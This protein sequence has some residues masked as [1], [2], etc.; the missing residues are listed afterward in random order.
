MATEEI[1]TLL[2]PIIEKHNKILSENY[3]IEK[4]PRMKDTAI[5]NAGSDHLFGSFLKD[6][7]LLSIVHGFAFYIGRNVD[8][9]N[10]YIL[11]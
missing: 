4:H 6:I 9:N 5:I 8:T 3:T 1:I 11:I 10:L 2:S 7:A